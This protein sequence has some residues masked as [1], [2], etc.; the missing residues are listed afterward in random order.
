MAR[1]ISWLECPPVH[2]K[3]A[4]SI[5]CQGTYRYLGCRFD[6]WSRCLW[7][8]TDGVFSVTLMS[9]SLCLSKIQQSYPRERVKKCINKSICL[10]KMPWLAYSVRTGADG[11]FSLTLMSIC[12]L[13]LSSSLPLSLKSIIKSISLD[14]DFSLKSIHIYSLIE[15]L[16]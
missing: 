1:W 8:A 12:L 13:S 11:C 14:E 7:K 6:P 16:C 15:L 3:V 2:Q 4:G 9:L 5:P 10:K